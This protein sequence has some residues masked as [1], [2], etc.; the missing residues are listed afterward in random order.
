MS[1][2]ILPAEALNLWVLPLPPS[3][4]VFDGTFHFTRGVV[5][6]QWADSV[7]FHVN[8]W[9]PSAHSCSLSF[10]YLTGPLAVDSF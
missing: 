5:L 9:C 1:E 2:H 10:Q 7:L 3:W 6:R 8:Y 4:G